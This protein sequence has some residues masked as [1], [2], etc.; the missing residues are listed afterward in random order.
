MVDIIQEEISQEGIIPVEEDNSRVVEANSQVIEAI[1][2]Q[3]ML[4]I[5]IA[6][7]KDIGNIQVIKDILVAVDNLLMDCIQDK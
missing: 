7:L 5:I 3:V 2:S 1:S 4:S 6:N